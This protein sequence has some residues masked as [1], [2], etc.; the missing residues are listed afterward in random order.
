ME[1][2]VLSFMD[3]LTALSL[4]LNITAMTLILVMAYKT[5]KGLT[6]SLQDQLLLASDEKQAIMNIISD[7]DRIGPFS[8]KG[9]FNIT[10]GT[11]TGKLSIGITYV[12]ILVQF[13]MSVQ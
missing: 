5:V 13:K 7:I 12:N 3:I 4:I 8:G 6:S 1:R 2:V 10:N 9:F 11:L